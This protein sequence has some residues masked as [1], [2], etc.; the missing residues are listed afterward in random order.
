MVISEGKFMSKKKQEI[1]YRE[2]IKQK[3]FIL[4]FLPTFFDDLM[5]VK[6]I[7]YEG[8]NLKVDFLIDIVHILL[9]KY[10]FKKKNKAPLNAEVMRKRYG[11]NYCYYIKYLSEKKIIHLETEYLK[12]SHSR[13][14]SLKDSI[15]NQKLKRYENRDKTLLKK[16]KSI[17]LSNS[18][19]IGNNLIDYDIREKLIDD[20]FY[21]NI[22]Y[23][24]SIEY[25]NNLDIEK[26]DKYDIYN[27]NM[28]AV[29]ALKKKDLFYSFDEYGRFHTNFT[30]LN[31][32]VRKN[33]LSIRNKRFK[34]IDISN[35]QPLFLAKLIH[36]SKTN[37]VKKEEF[38][39]FKSLTKNGEYYQYV[40]EKLNIKDKVKVK[41][42]TYNVL[43][44]ENKL[45]T[46]KNG[47]KFRTKKN[48]NFQKLFPS[49][50]NFILLYKKEHKNYK[51]LACELQK[52]ESNVIYNKIVRQIIDNDPSVKLF[53]VHDSIGIT[54]EHYE[55]A[56]NIF[57][58]TL[59][60]EFNF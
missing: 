24:E 48:A 14:Y 58:K 34:E 39:K 49:I 25:L 28:H 42:M 20:L 40:M 45:Y 55:F 21:I 51:A 56:N 36:E 23:K 5:D 33:Y 6:K 1:T 35:S 29:E 47:N 18:P 54:E 13:I 11:M 41:K 53:T 2:K 43:F 30:V 37:W 44:G 50:F 4:Q 60:S 57:Q 15:L 17:Y 52:K 10:H 19:E 7:K 12:N 46:D 26:N 38:E 27:K 16:Y 31:S 59:L 9:T 22:D 3:E 32:F 8:V